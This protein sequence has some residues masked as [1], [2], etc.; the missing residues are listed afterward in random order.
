MLFAFENDIDENGLPDI[1]KYCSVD[2]TKR[3]VVR[4]MEYRPLYA[5]DI[6]TTF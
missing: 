4:G 2:S 5:T 1:D 3:S 6:N